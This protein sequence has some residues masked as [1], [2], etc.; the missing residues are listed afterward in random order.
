[1]I[2]ANLSLGEI[3]VG[4]SASFTRV[5][6]EKDLRQFAELS[7]DT[8]PL[9][10]DEEFAKTTQFKARLVHGML[11]GSLCSQFVGMHIPG[12]HC[13]YLKQSLAFKKPVFIGDEVNVTGTVIS[14]SDSTGILSIQI[15]IR[16]QDVVVLE[17][18]AQVQVI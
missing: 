16:K 7:G 6:T 5:W 10:M 3:F 17:G 14:K 8:N 15:I 13:L 18:E 2:P 11:V 12:K 1:M 9:H 4:Q